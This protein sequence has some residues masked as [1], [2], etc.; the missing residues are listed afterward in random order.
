MPTDIV[1]FFKQ[2][3]L[4]DPRFADVD[5]REGSAINDILIASISVLNRPLDNDLA[6]LIRGQ[7]L[8]NF[9]AMTDIEMDALAANFS[10]VRAP[11]N[12][13]RAFVRLSFS[14]PVAID[15]ATGQ[16]FLTGAGL[17][18]QTEARYFLS[19]SAFSQRVDANGFYTTD[20]IPVIAEEPG[21]EYL[22]EA[23]AIIEMTAP[24]PYF[25]SV[26]NLQPATGGADRE[27][28]EALQNRLRKGVSTR[29]ILNEIGTEYRLREHFPDLADIEM[30]GFG[31]REMERD[32]IFFAP[33]DDTG[34]A[35][36]DFEA[37]IR[38]SDTNPSRAYALLISQEVPALSDFSDE[39]SQEAYTLLAQ[40][41][42]AQFV[43]VDSGLI[44]E[45]DFDRSV[46]GLTPKMTTLSERVQDI[47]P[48]RVPV[49]DGALI[50]AND[51]VTI[52][53]PDRTIILTSTD[54]T[55][56][57]TPDTDSLEVLGIGDVLTF[58]GTVTIPL[59][60][61]SDNTNTISIASAAAAGLN[62]GDSV[63]VKVDGGGGIML[64][65][66]ATGT[67]TVVVDASE[68]A[69]IAP[70]AMVTIRADGLPDLSRNV[71]ATSGT[72]ITLDNVV[73]A[74]YTEALRARII[75]SSQA[76]L[77]RTVSDVTDTTIVL[78]STIPYG[79]A[80]Q[81]NA[82]VEIAGPF[83]RTIISI[84]SDSIAIN[85]PLL[86]GFTGAEAHTDPVTASVI[87]TSGDALTISSPLTTAFGTDATVK[88]IHRD[89]SIGN[90][91]LESEHGNALAVETDGHSVTIENGRVVL[92][93]ASYATDDTLR[94]LY[95]NNNADQ[96]EAQIRQVF[97][98]TLKDNGLD[99]LDRA[100]V[101]TAIDDLS[102]DAL[103]SALQLSAT[104]A[105]SPVLQR[106]LSVHNGIRITGTFETNDDSSTGRYC[107]VTVLKNNSGNAQ[108]HSGFGFAWRKGST[109]TV[110]I[111]D[112]GDLAAQSEAY[113][114]KAS[115]DID[116]DTRYRF[117]MLLNAPVSGE[118]AASA[119]EV[120]IWEDDPLIARPSSPTLSYG[121]YTPIN[122]RDTNAES[123]THFG[124]SVAGAAGSQWYID[125]LRI[126]SIASRYA[127]L[128]ARFYVPILSDRFNVQAR[129]RGKGADEDGSVAYGGALK[130]WSP[131]ANRFDT[132]AK[133]EGNTFQNLSADTGIDVDRY[134]DSANHIYV[135]ISSLHPS[136]SIE[137]AVLDI[138]YLGVFED[139]SGGVHVGG[140]TDVY[141]KT[142]ERLAYAELTIQS[143][144]PPLFRLSSDTGA[145]LPIA[146]I[147]AIY[148]VVGGV[149]SGTPLVAGTDYSHFVGEGE[150]N[151]SSS[152]NNA[153]AFSPA[154]RG[155]AQDMLVQY[156]YFPDIAQMQAFVD[157]ITERTTDGD[158]LVRGF[159]P[160][161]VDATIGVQ[162]SPISHTELASRL[163]A[164]I[165]SLG[166]TIDADTD[167]IA[168]LKGQGV[169][170]VSLPVVLTTEELLFSGAS[171]T[172]TVQ[173]DVTIARTARFYPRNIFIIQGT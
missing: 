5:V 12:R 155:L 80:T 152:E 36:A 83:R 1:T 105:V 116:T 17:V 131:T 46:Q 87:A 170:D 148:P 120:R 104:Q 64:S 147:D 8:A 16:T 129:I 158:W 92:G 136:R 58:T 134:R 150:I 19:R 69:A 82:R 103:I 48:R 146:Y 132:I 63:E 4:A 50:F 153:I 43:Q 114:S 167:F 101:N 61:N 84:D 72:A 31:D 21:T 42:D 122:A 68:I 88:K 96:L 25:V 100:L 165:W 98:Q 89:E 85:V 75:V 110:F 121:A 37:K 65:A 112:N 39:L 54:G 18:W 66:D 26:T 51:R 13:A 107:Y 6:A 2:T 142:Q 109:D 99:P 126:D 79:F 35:I 73:P 32:K 118:P 53:Q 128:L 27:D 49:E 59:A 160:V 24:P 41:R 7:S 91:W 34:T 125:D 20:D 113:L 130:I 56:I 28:N 52:T 71:S 173:D 111:V 140:K 55:A 14:A 76:S 67:N 86:K 93:K 171:K 102:V 47:L 95:N 45:D 106:A 11:G 60:E 3:L 62:V 81:M 138:D 90:A 169:T 38:H 156:H 78:D 164:H 149:Q 139:V 108:Y 123:H 44:F 23:G 97:S 33:E 70:N 157:L 57:L 144:I 124:I 40:Q 133:N 135:L 163:S 22:V 166:T 145:R 151:F 154:L 159:R 94:I 77:V 115:V 161:F 119:I 117:E 127:H 30:V 74:T 15:I 29:Q 143:P 141:V 9:E 172:A 162:G 137:N 10:A 168:Y